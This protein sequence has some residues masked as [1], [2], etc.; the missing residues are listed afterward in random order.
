M[1]VGKMTIP[2]PCAI[3]F[4]KAQNVHVYTEH[5]QRITIIPEVYNKLINLTLI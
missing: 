4:I 5:I 3:I 1:H 2:K